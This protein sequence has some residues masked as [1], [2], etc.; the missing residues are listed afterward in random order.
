VDEARPTG[1]SD[2]SFGGELSDTQGPIGEI[3]GF[4]TTTTA[5]GAWYLDDGREGTWELGSQ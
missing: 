1:C 2:W 5:G 3:D 4:L